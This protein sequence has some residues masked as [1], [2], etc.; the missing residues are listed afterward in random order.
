M[1]QSAYDHGSVVSETGAMLSPELN[2]L[3]QETVYIFALLCHFGD[4]Q[5]RR[6]RDLPVVRAKQGTSERKGN[7]M[8]NT[9]DYDSTF[10]TMKHAH[11]RLFISLINETFGKNYPLSSEVIEV[12]PADM[13]L[14]VADPDAVQKLLAERD[15]DF[16]IRIG[17]DYYL[18]E[19]QVYDDDTMALRI[20]EYTFL[21]ARQYA[22]G[23]QSQVTLNIPHFTVLYIKATNKT[24]RTTVIRYRFPNGKTVECTENNIFLSDYS[25][26]D[27]FAK[28]LYALLPFYIAR[29]ER[30]LR[31][32]KDYENAL[33]DLA[34]IRD[35]MVQSL[36]S[37]ELD[38]KEFRDLHDSIIRIITHITDGN[39]IEGRMVTTM[40]GE[41]YET[42]SERIER[43][44]GERFAGII[45]LKD[46][47]LADKDEQLA[48]KDEQL[49]DKDEQL[50]DK[51]EQLAD[52]NRE[53]AM[54]R[55]QLAKYGK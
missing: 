23:D 53:I 55:E 29:Y 26:P 47:Q 54:L 10:K 22:Q 12:L 36:Q 45:A 30:E 27:I 1:L 24:P 15:N 48:D 51:D 13:I 32:E 37:G 8:R 20:A 17:G 6:L 14:P 38:I 40:G 25:L 44:V 9:N 39:G 50:A 33:I 49:A 2:V 11:K 43:E 34:F 3:K 5:V 7:F 4:C 21:A 41:I 19:S 28:K 46:E 31:T 42:A 16:L 18:I 52:V 35:S